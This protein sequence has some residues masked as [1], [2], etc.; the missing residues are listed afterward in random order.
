[1]GFPMMQTDQAGTLALAEVDGSNDVF[2]STN[3]A[4]D[5]NCKDRHQDDVSNAHVGGNSSNDGDSL[6]Q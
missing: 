2:C 6:K 3:N 1:M 4:I 5:A